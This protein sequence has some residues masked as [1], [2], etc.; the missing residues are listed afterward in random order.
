M[1]L[2]GGSADGRVTLVCRFFVRFFFGLTIKAVQ[3]SLLPL[4]SFTS[5][6]YLFRFHRSLALRHP[7]S[8]M[9]SATTV[10]VNKA[11]I[12][13]F[14]NTNHDLWVAEAQ[15]SLQDVQSGKGLNPGEV[16][17]EVRSTGICG[18]ASIFFLELRGDYDN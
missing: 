11:N 17:V 3:L 15:P 1:L 10:T 12:G 2:D 5:S 8:T 4:L 7:T 18:Y 6:L 14:T 16:T 13:V 9:A